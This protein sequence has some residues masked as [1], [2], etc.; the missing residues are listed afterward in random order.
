MNMPSRP[1]RVFVVDDEAPARARLK[2]LLADI[3]A[4]CPNALVG[5]ADSGALALERLALL[6]DTVDVVLVD[7]RMPGMDGIDLAVHLAAREPGPALIFTT[8]YDQYAVK[9]F[10]LNAA[11]YLLKPVR[12]QR[13]QAALDK[14]RERRSAVAASRR[15]RPEGRRQ[16]A[17]SERGRILLVAVADILFLRADQKYVCAHT[18]AR[19]YLLEESLVQLEQEF[20][21]TFI[22]I[23]RN[24]L[25][26]REAISGFEKAPDGAESQWLVCLNGLA[27]KLPVS[28]RQW[29]HLKAEVAA[30]ALAERGV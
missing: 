5:E 29:P 1:L 14:A 24:C 8:A 18:P 19:E 22:R 25:V 2:A 12:A 26:A 30:A 28:R 17:C 9:A 10:D 11:D 23:H 16:L 27:E 3:G 4:D 6:G 7:I 15:L 13:L 21:Q 20:G